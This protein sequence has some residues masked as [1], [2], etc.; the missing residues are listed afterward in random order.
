VSPYRKTPEVQKLECWLAGAQRR[1]LE[2][3]ERVEK[4]EAENRIL[5]DALRVLMRDAEWKR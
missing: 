3:A 5:R 1:E 2:A 4:L